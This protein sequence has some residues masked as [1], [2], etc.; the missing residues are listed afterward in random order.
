VFPATGSVNEYPNRSSET[1]LDRQIPKTQATH[2]RSRTRHASLSK[3]CED[4]EITLSI[5]AT[6]AHNQNGII[7]AG[8]MILRISLI[9][10]ELQNHNLVCR[11][12]WNAQ[13]LGRI[14]VRGPKSLR[15]T[16]FGWKSYRRHAVWYNRSA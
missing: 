4:T 6:E 12:L 13:Y 5:V 7:E 14:A 1:S 3:F 9:E 15:R 2:R 10:S 11:R 16:N 8:N